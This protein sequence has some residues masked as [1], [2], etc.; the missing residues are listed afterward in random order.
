MTRE[1]YNQAFEALGFEYDSEYNDRI[2]YMNDRCEAIILYKLGEAITITYGGMTAWIENDT[3]RHITTEY[4]FVTKAMMDSY[5]TVL[6]NTI[7]K[8]LTSK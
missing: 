1:Q 6:Q 3:V 2:Y 8:V 4:K 7:N 5:R